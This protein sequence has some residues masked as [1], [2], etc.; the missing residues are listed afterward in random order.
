MEKYFWAKY[1]ESNNNFFKIMALA[2]K[3]NGGVNIKKT[4]YFTKAVDKFRQDGFAKIYTNLI[5]EFGKYV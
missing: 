1:I 3:K 5:T 2:V 4:E